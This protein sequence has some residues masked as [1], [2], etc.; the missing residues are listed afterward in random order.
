MNMKKNM[1][2]VISL[3]AFC[4]LVIGLTWVSKSSKVYSE[5][6]PQTEIRT[7]SGVQR[8]NDKAKAVKGADRAAIR[9]L[10]DEIMSQY[11]WDAAPSAITDS[12][13]DRLVSAEENFHN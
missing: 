2:V 5:S 3:S 8:I 4:L 1:K 6:Q 12:L 10:T 13:K 11:G 9:G 7:K